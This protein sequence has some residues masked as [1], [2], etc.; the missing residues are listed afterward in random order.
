M[1]IRARTGPICRTSS[2]P[3]MPISV[4]S[5]ATMYRMQAPIAYGI[6]ISSRLASSSS[7]V[8]QSC[9]QRVTTRRVY[10]ATNVG[11]PAT[12]T[13][14]SSPMARARIL[15][16]T[17]VVKRTSPSLTAMRIWWSSISMA[18]LRLLRFCLAANNMSGSIKHSM[19]PPHLG[20][21]S[22]VTQV[23]TLRVITVNGRQR[24]SK[25]LRYQR[26]M[27]LQANASSI[28]VAMTTR[29][30]I[31]IRMVC[32][33]CALVADATPTTSSRQVSQMRSTPCSTVRFRASL[34]LIWLQMQARSCLLLM[35]LWVINSTNMSSILQAN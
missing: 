7:R 10:R 35:T 4:S 3:Q 32:T 20:Y 28:S 9:L 31:S 13:S 29:L 12:T 5:M 22:S 8:R 11:H 1:A 27:R 34:R 17:L 18:M 21:S 19:H 6:V 30:N 25:W 24:L 16:Q 23:S 2:V 33:M 15:S 26:N 14:G